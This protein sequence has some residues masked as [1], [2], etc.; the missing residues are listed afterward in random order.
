M[1]DY[2][3]TRDP[4]ELTPAKLTRDEVQALASYR[5]ALAAHAEHHRG[6]QIEVVV[7][8]IPVT[9]EF[10]LDHPELVAEA[11]ASES[12]RAARAAVEDRIRELSSE[13]PT[14]DA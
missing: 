1:D 11:C 13:H 14:A 7:T 9:R 4:K 3:F 2:H 6:S 10:M 5:E 8:V 12:A